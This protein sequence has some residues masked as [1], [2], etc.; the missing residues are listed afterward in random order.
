MYITCSNNNGTKYLRLV[1]STKVLDEDGK[2]KQCP[3]TVKS[4]GLLSKDDDELLPYVEDNIH[5]HLYLSHL[6]MGGRVQRKTFK[7]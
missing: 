2:Y 5:L 7:L 1:K 3:K 4:H 6:P